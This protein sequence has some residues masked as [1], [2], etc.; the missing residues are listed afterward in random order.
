LNR[1]K[2]DIDVYPNTTTVIVSAAAYHELLSL[3]NEGLQKAA[4]RDAVLLLKQI[5][6]RA[7]RQEEAADLV[8]SLQMAA[9]Q[10]GYFQ[11]AA[12]IGIEPGSLPELVA[13]I[14]IRPFTLVVSKSPVR[15]VTLA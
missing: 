13:M 11:I 1:N 4:E 9:Q 6:S 14:H 3:F 10:G 8:R 12:R 2:P 5:V 15:T 7:Q